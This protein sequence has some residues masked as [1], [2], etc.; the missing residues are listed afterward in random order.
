[1]LKENYFSFLLTDDTSLNPIPDISYDLRCQSDSIRMT[2]HCKVM[3]VVCCPVSEKSLALILSDSRVIF[4][5]MHT[6]DFQVGFLRYLGVG[7]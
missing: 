5:E 2:R 7:R 4:W 3:G 1:M 6:V